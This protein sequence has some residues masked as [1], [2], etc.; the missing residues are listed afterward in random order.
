MIPRS[1]VAIETNKFPIL[2]G[3]DD[4]IV[5]ENMY[6]K[7]LCKYLENI[8]P[9][10]GIKVLTYFPED[11]GWWLEVEDNDFNMALCIYSDPEA[12]HDPERYAILPSILKE[13]KWSWSQFK[14][15]DLS[16]NVLKIMDALEKVFKEDAEIRAVT[17]HDDFPY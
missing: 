14:Y 16:K 4:E 17:R 7:A 15:I 10:T 2:E 8:L 5:N 9:K 6:G 13:K 1:C 11:W 3:E 12:K